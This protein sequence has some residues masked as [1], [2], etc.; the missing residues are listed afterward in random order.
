MSLSTETDPQPLDHAPDHSALQDEVL[1]GLRQDPKRLHPK[2]FYDATGAALFERICEQPEYYPT[3]TELRITSDH[4]AEMAASIG[5]H[6]LLIELGSGSGL[7]TRM[8][9]ELLEE[10]AGYVPVDISAAQL[11]ETSRELNKL[12]PDL[13]VLPV[14]A[15]FTQP[16]P[17]PAPD[18]EVRSRA[19]YFPGSTIGNFEPAGVVA[20][21]ERIA[22]AVSHGGGLL[23]GVDLR[24]DPAILEAA[25]N[26]A[27]GVPRAFNLNVLRHLNTSVGA[28]F[29]L[30]SFRH[31]AWFNRTEGRIEMHLVSSRRQVVTIAGE[32]IGF[33]EGESIHT[34][35]SYKFSRDAFASLAAQAG[36]DVRRVWTD[37]QELFSVQYLTVP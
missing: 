4:G 37:D 15:D 26:D 24:K 33:R 12:F 1:A 9:L 5:P 23:I 8:L 35:N 32:Q 20:L 17:V 36:L 18:R 14:R 2:F 22:A 30:D 11:V 21:L 34:E 25:Y 16:F 13:Q 6:A 27:A 29:D 28:D 3:R 19:V 10:P 7:K 31:H